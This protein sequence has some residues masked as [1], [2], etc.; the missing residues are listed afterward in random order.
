MNGKY[1]NFISPRTAGL[2][3]SSCQNS[4]GKLKTLLHIRTIFLHIYVKYTP[5]LFST[6][7]MVW[8]F[9]WISWQVPRSTDGKKWE[10]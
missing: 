5:F 10:V 4:Q 9:C 1:I 7:S 3:G 6:L 2:K 8:C